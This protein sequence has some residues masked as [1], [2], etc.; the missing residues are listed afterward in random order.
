MKIRAL[1]VAR[2]VDESEVAEFEIY[3]GTDWRDGEARNF[4]EDS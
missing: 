4:S 1:L 2:Y 3:L